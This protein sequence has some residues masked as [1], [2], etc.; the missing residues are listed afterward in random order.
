MDEMKI[1]SNFMKAILSTVIS[2]YLR[3]KNLDIDVSIS[4]FE[5]KRDD[6]SKKTKIN[7]RVEGTCTD[8]QLTRMINQ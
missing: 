8:E 7:V 1:Q 5:M 4:E 6:H 3:S 2:K